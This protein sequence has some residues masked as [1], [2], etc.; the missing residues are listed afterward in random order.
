M[1]HE[2][3]TTAGPIPANKLGI[4]IMHEHIVID[5]R[6][7]WF[8]DGSEDF[9]LDERDVAEREIRE[10][11]QAGGATIVDVTTL[12]MNRDV[13][14][15][16]AI[17]QRAGVQ[18]ILAT[19]FYVQRSYPP[20]V[21][22]ASIDQLADIMIAE[23]EEGMDGTGIRA[24]IIGEIASGAEPLAPVE[25]K[26]FRAAAKAH[27][28]TGLAITT[29]THLG[30][31][32]LDQLHLLMD[33]GVDPARII[34]GHL[35]SRLH[36]ENVDEHRE[37]GRLGAYIQYDGVGHAYYSTLS[38]TQFPFDEERIWAIQQL[39]DWGLG[40]RI[41]LSHDTC[42]KR[43]LKAHGG[44]GYDHV[45]SHFVPMLDNA[46]ISRQAINAMLIENPRR[47]LTGN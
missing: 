11:V 20:Y 46:G 36:Q 34:I 18:L 10:Y 35:D 16:A 14:G 26:I 5:A 25:E 44:C 47:V 9:V 24:G 8:T 19:G 29:H 6:H 2:I 12:G 32:G 1:P 4:T 7:I 13:A 22:D 43:H 3:M 23:I 40:D 21:H 17:A 28:A 42:R 41:L 37:I 38:N 45:V 15:V 31:R 39:L 30:R 27:H 33:A